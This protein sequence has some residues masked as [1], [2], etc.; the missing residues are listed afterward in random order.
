MEKEHTYR[1]TAWWTSGQTGITK[2]SSSPNAIH[3]AAPPQFGGL[4]GRW[5][6]EDMLLSAIASCYTTTFQAVAGYSKFE[7]IDLE[8]KMEGTIAKTS[9]GYA[10]TGIVIRPTLRVP[11]E[12]GYQRAL[13]LLEKAKNLCLVS[14]ALSVPQ[15]FEACVEVRDA[16]QTV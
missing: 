14:G 8:V 5:T 12:S 6:P 9:T 4:E 2:S 3:F 13:E 10:F 15:E 1:V 11:E 16:V 7:F